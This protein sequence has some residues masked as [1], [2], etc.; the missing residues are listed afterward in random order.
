[1]PLRMTI[2]IR[3]FEGTPESLS[4]FVIK[5]W[6]AKYSHS[7]FAPNW[8][9]DY[10]RWQLPQFAAG[11]MSGIISAYDGTTL[12]GVNPLLVVPITFRGR[13]EMAVMGDWITTDISRKSSGIGRQ[14]WEANRQYAEQH[15]ALFVAG[16]NNT[17]S[18]PGEGHKFW[19]KVLEGNR[20][21]LNKPRS[22][23]RILNGKKLADAVWDR[24]DQ[25][26]A[27]VGGWINRIYSTSPAANVRDYRPGDAAACHAVFENYMGRF[28]LSYRWDQA[29]LAYHLGF[30]EPA[31][32]LVL[33]KAGVIKGL[34]SFSI[35]D[36]FG[37]ATMRNGIID[38]LAWND[39]STADILGLLRS[40]LD[41]MRARDVDIVLTFGPPMIAG[42]VLV[43]AG[44][45]PMPSSYKSLVIPTK[46]GASLETIKT[47]YVYLR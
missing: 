31:H 41:I 36:V 43:R 22:W 23:A 19:K 30:G 21:L 46:P 1:V 44:F 15:D 11:R 33:E 16:V 32:A 25:I 2:E 14:L 10:F 24:D 27:Q 29:R 8:T 26:S 6:R 40:A 34:I 45:L 18:I 28:E 3:D 5:H 38:L 13:N 37:R 9:P 4:E 7:G 47:A 17:G 39:L 12:V 20:I 42:S 35:L